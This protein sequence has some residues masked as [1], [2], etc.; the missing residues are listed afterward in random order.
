MALAIA[1]WVRDTAIQAG[2]RDLNNQKAFA[3]AIY[4]TKTTMNTQ[5]KGQEGYKKDSIFDRMNDA[6]SM[7]EQFKWIIK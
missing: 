6:K 3:D 2:A 5:I 7:Y 1:C 4:T